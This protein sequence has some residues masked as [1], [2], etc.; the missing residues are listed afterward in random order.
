MR[1]WGL[2]HGYNGHHF[3]TVDPKVRCSHGSSMPICV[4][5]DIAAWQDTTGVIEIEIIRV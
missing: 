1:V 2:G 5:E 4:A 3:E